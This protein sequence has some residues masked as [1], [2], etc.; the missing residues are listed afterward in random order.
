MSYSTNTYEIIRVNKTMYLISAELRTNDLKFH[1]F[2]NLA[3]SILCWRIIKVTRFRS[4]TLVA[5]RSNLRLTSVMF[6]TSWRTLLF[7]RVE[8]VRIFSHSLI[9]KQ[10][11]EYNIYSS[12]WIIYWS[13]KAG[14]F[15]SIIYFTSLTKVTI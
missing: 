4:L 8:R 10:K 9:N 3:S 12:S 14:F 1:Y 11:T 13:S 6:G 7:R 15:K 2:R 5:A